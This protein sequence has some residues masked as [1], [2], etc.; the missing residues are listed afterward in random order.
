[1][2]GAGKQRAALATGPAEAALPLP[3]AIIN[4]LATGSSDL[5]SL[6]SIECEERSRGK[7][8]PSRDSQSRGLVCGQSS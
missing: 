2:T 6:V 3:S 4:L 8:T 7:K 1:M 5:L